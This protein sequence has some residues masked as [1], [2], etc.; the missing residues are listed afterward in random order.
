MKTFALL[1]SLFVTA[2]LYATNQKPEILI[3]DGKIFNYFHVW[4]L[5]EY[6]K[7]KK[8]PDIFPG[9]TA[10]ARGYIGIWTIDDNKLYLLGLQGSMDSNRI[11]IKILFPQKYKDGKVYA[12]WFTG[13]FFVNYGESLN[14]Y[15]PQDDMFSEYEGRLV[16]EVKDGKI[17]KT[18]ILN[19]KSPQTVLFT[20]KKVLL[21]DKKKLEKLEGK[22]FDN[23][24]DIEQILKEME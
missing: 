3:Y 9:S 6:Y 13:I 18:H 7:D 10:L 2:S 17:E 16:F 21:V 8:R 23:N 15:P 5:E 19:S 11:D 12:D 20:G 22:S 1:F 14:E 4:P 24:D